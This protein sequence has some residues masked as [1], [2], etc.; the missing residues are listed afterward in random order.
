MDWKE[1]LQIAENLHVHGIK[2][3]PT[4]ESERVW[5][6]DLTSLNRTTIARQGHT[7]FPHPSKPRSQVRGSKQ[8]DHIVSELSL[9]SSDII[10]IKVGG[11]L[12]PAATCKWLC[13]FQ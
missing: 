9:Y 1:D 7:A 11:P 6:K 4:L 13:N 8:D 3:M 5:M 12:A 10:Q 2:L